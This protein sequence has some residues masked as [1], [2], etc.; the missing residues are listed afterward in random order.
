M[1]SRH[2]GGGS[3]KDSRE[4]TIAYCSSTRGRALHSSSVVLVKVSVG[5][6]AAPALADSV[7]AAVVAV[8]MLM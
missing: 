4:I 5:R 6:A 2:W 1:A 3:N 8:V 7:I